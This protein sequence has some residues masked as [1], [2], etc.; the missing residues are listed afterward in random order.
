MLGPTPGSFSWSE[1]TQ[2]VLSARDK[3]HLVYQLVRSQLHERLSRLAWRLDRSRIRRRGVELARLRPPHSAFCRRVEDR[4][5][6]EY[7]PALL[8]HCYRTWWMGALVGEMLG[9]E[10]DAET[11]YVACLM[12][13]VGLTDGHA[14]CITSTAFQVTGAREARRLALDAQ[15]RDADAIRL[16]EAIS[17]HLNPWLDAGRHTPEALLVKYGAHMDVAGAHRHLLPAKTLA[18]IHRRHPRDGFRQEITRSIESLPHRTG[19]HAEVLRRMGFARLAERNPLDRHH[20][21]GAVGGPTR[22]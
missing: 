4:V 21:A 20:G 19:S 18:E 16:Y 9:L 22:P 11:L 14:G 6:A 7:S 10:A 8:A 2:G 15:W 17:Y 3:A 13:D 5:A 12:H 1:T